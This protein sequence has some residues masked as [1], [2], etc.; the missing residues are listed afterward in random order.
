MYLVDVCEQVVVKVEVEWDSLGVYNF[1]S[2]VYF[3]IY[4]Y[5]LFGLFCM[6]DVGVQFFIGDVLKVEGY[7]ANEVFYVEVFCSFFLMWFSVFQFVLVLQVI[8][9]LLLI[10]LVFGSIVWEWEIGILKMLVFQGV[11]FW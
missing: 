5:W 7:V 1:Y 3:G 11:F 8:V 2:V 9:F 4:V 6:L 10:F